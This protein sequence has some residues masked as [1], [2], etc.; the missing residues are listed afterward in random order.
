MHFG[1]EIG[2]HAVRAVAGASGKEVIEI[3]GVGTSPA[4]GLGVDGAV[5]HPERLVECILDAV[6]E[7]EDSAGARAAR[8][9]VA[10]PGALTRTQVVEGRVSLEDRLATPGDLE[11]AT[12]AALALRDESMELLHAR[13]QA[14]VV[15]EDAQGRA[16]AELRVT[17]LV[18]AVPR[19]AL[20]AHTHCVELAGLE[21]DGVTPA[22]IAAA[23]VALSAT[24]RERGV[25]LCHLEGQLADLVVYR[26]GAL[27]HVASVP[28]STLLA[29]IEQL[30][31]VDLL[32]GGIVFTG[33]EV[34]SHISGGARAAG[35]PTHRPGGDSERAALA[36]GVGVLLRTMGEEAERRMRVAG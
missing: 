36:A 18:I 32:P 7:A 30:G 33:D 25:V 28:A 13:L 27:Q 23:E 16:A 4:W 17:L 22:P 19:A 15:D 35:I 31:G 5:T 8:V 2:R 34:P 11:R 10:I 21:V 14:V 3:L 9:H 6:G 24:D 1:L 26:S 12:Q 29:E 20:E